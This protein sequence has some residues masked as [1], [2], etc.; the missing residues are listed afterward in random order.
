MTGVLGMLEVVLDTNLSS[1]QKEYL[2]TA[3]S[4]GEALLSLLND[5]LDL[6]KI[7][8][9]RLELIPA[10]FSI[11]KLVEDAVRMFEVPVQQSGLAVSVQIEPDVPDL[12]VGDVARLRQVVL[13]L[14]GNAVKFTERGRIVLRVELEEHKP[15]EVSLHFLVSDTGIGI[16]EED[17][18]WIFEPFR[19]VDGSASRRFGGT[20]LGL[21]ICTRLVN[22]M[23]GRIWV[24]SRWGE[25]S[26][27]HFTAAFALASVDAAKQPSDAHDLALLTSAVFSVDLPPVPPLRILV[28]EDN[29]VNQKLIVH[30]LRKQGHDVVVAENGLEAL[31]ALKKRSFDLVLMDVQMP[32][33]D[34]F[35]ATA[36]IRKME[37]GTGT[38]LPIVAMTAHAMAGDR[39]KCTQAGMDDYLSKPLNFR[40]LHTTLGKWARKISTV[41]LPR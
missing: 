9:Q 30:V 4:S 14:L 36:A 19:Q 34:G 15:S 27:F 10:T 23:G 35:E 24:E 21:A 1:E 6:S 32:R 2:E 26:K 8:A 20:G 5:I 18:A 11:R 39:E 12:L 41:P 28:G 38:H 16:R 37:H 22:L 7:E 3:R 17:Q 13:N 25:G 40:S 29:A 33:M 31:A